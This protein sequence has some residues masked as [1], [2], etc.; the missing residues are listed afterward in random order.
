MGRFESRKKHD[1]ESDFDDE[2]ELGMSIENFSK[3][4]SS[5][6]MNE[7]ESNKQTFKPRQDYSQTCHTVLHLDAKRS[8]TLG[9][10]SY[11]SIGLET[12]N[13]STLFKQSIEDYV[14]EPER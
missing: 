14:S 12:P 2:E 1:G 3:S 7:K 10:Q 13:R 6:I 9:P 8:L 5:S 4:Y 11:E